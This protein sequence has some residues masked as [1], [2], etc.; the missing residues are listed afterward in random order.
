MV[1][2]TALWLPI[3]LS[4][5]AIFFASF[6]IHTVLGY[7]G[8]D[9]QR[10]PTDKED[11]VMEAVRR[12]TVAPGD[13]AAPHAGSM[14]GMRD[15]AFVAKVTKGPRVFMTIFPGSAPSLGPYLLRWFIYSIVVC[16]FSAY[17]VG[18]AIGPGA[19]FRVVL[20]FTWVT[21]FIGFGLA[22]PQLSIW[23]H[24]S[25]GTT[26]RYTIDGL[27]FGLLSGGVFG[28]LWPKM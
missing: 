24:R 2:V 8:N 4:A 27:I 17:V 11:D 26:I 25:W 5:V 21:T 23:Y 22:L 20:H 13:Y 1:S 16:L 7:H 10:L 28:W 3:L 19:A 18:G 12:L 15:P 14:A 9:V 6:L